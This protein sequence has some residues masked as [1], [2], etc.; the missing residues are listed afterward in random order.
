M[1]KNVQTSGNGRHGVDAGGY[2]KNE[3]RKLSRRGEGFGALPPGG[4]GKEK[5]RCRGRQVSVSGSL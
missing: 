2:H 4:V 3:E 5:D 1:E